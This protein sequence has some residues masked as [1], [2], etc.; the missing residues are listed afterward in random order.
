[1]EIGW[2]IAADR[3]GNVYFATGDPHSVFKL[4]PNRT[5]T[6]IAGNGMFGYSGEGGIAT[7]AQFGISGTVGIAADS[8]GNVFIAD[9]LNHRIRKVTKDGIV[10]TVAGNGTQGYSGDGGPAT[11]A[12]LS[13]PSAIAVDTVGNLYIT[14]GSS[15]TFQANGANRVRRIGLDGI[16][17]TVAGNGSYGFSGDGG[18]AI[19]AQ[20]NEPSA[21]AVD[22]EGNLF[23]ADEVNNRIRKVSPS[24]IITTLAGGGTEGLGD[25]GPAT[26]AQ[27]RSPIS[28]TVD[29]NGNLF[30]ADF[31]N[32]RVRKVSPDGIIT[33]VAGV[34]IEGFSGDGGPAIS[35]QLRFPA[36]VA[37]DGAGSLFMVDFGNKR[38]RKLTT[39]GTITTVV[40]DGGSTSENGG[41]ADDGAPATSVRLDPAGVAVDRDGNLFIAEY[42]NN[43]IRKVSRGGSITTVAGNGAKGFSGDGGP[44]IDAQLNRPRA[45]TLDNHGNLFISDSGNT[46]IRK[47]SA[48]GIITTAAQV[49]SWGLAVDDSGNLFTADR[50]SNR[51]LRVSPDGTTTTVAGNGMGGLY[52]DGGPATS[53]PVWC[54]NAVAVDSSGNLFIGEYCGNRVRKV[55]P[56]GIINTVAGGGT[57]SGDGGPATSAGLF[58][59]SGVS[60]DTAGN[61]FIST[62]DFDDG[63]IFEQVRKVS[64]DGIIKTVAGIGTWG[65]SGDGGL[66]VYAQLNAPIGSTVDSAGNVYIADYGNGVVRI[67][68][69]IGRPVWISGV[70]DAASQKLAAIAPGKLLE[71]YGSGLG[72]AQP[73]SQTGPPSMELAGTTVSFNGMPA[74]ILYS[75]ATQVAAIAPYTLAGA[76]AQIAVSYRGDNSEVFSVPVAPSSPELFTANQ[77][78]SGQA[79]ALNADGTVNSATNPIKIGD[80][81]TLYGTG[82][83]LSSIPDPPFL[84][85]CDALLRP[86]LPVSV[87]IGGIQAPVPCAGRRSDEAA[88]RVVVQ[89]PNGVQPGGYV[90]VVLKVGEAS[91]TPGAVWIAVSAK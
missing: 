25:G 65:F 86:I 37:V 26:N 27:L 3:E 72:P 60:V 57:Q 18:P 6:R 22:T 46:R 28:V 48:D 63:L 81:I 8:A 78:G 20:L 52:G 1:M 35:A 76:N 55:T 90:P 74:Q 67:L 88:M 44:A 9:W 62:S 10:I 54:P 85:S 66:A 5:L 4:D 42:G 16:I 58:Y 2:G 12:Q 82:E 51:V 79:A 80:S 30:I 75:S 69:P 71:I 89:I 73:V 53:A 40:G 91:T 19:S 39:D 41:P 45:L 29:R 34:G 50:F 13:G 47:V 43:R 11:S 33:T 59:I 24:G 23:I 17:T 68:R 32:N 70:A 49:S 31:Y 83:G 56:D 38:L 64:P 7:I 87:S 21:L 36:A 61:L 84:T 15:R 77:T 14:D